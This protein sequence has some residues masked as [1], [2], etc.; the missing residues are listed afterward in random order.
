MTR[1]Q[2]RE[3]HI[4]T[5]DTQLE[6]SILTIED[7]FFIKQVILYYASEAHERLSDKDRSDS[8]KKVDNIHVTNCKIVEAKLE[9]LLI[10]M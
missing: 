9:H 10:K 7:I 4:L 1:D 5:I 3:K 6:L 8:L 2:I